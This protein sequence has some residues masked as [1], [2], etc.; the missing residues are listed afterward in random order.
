MSQLECAL[1]IEQNHGGSHA[2]GVAVGA[3]DDVR[4]FCKHT[5]HTILSQFTE[6]FELLFDVSRCEH[7]GFHVS[8]GSEEGA[9]GVLPVFVQWAAAAFPFRGS[10]CASP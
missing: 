4:Q 8:D 10:N 6:G 5:G 7:R 1:E 3:F 9:F 2:A